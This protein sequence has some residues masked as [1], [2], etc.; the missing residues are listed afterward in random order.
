MNAAMI[1]SGGGPVVILTRHEVL[2]DQAL[3]GRLARKGVEKFIAF[4]IP[5]EV[6]R[7]RHGTHFNLVCGAVPHGP[8][9]FRLIGVSC[10]RPRCKKPGG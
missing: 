9:T 7:S 4:S 8:L 2:E 10:E 6:A 1:F 5:I 3:V